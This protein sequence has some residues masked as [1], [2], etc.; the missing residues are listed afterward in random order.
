[1]RRIYRLIIFVLNG[2]IYFFT[3]I[4]VE[5]YGGFWKF[6]LSCKNKPNTLKSKMY[7]KYQH[8]NACGI[9]QFSYFKGYPILPHG[10]FGIFI[11]AGA[12]IGENCVIFHHVTIGSNTLLDSKS[13][14]SPTIGDNVYIGAGA[15]II[16]NVHIGSNVRIGANAIVVK[17]VADNSIVVLDSIKTITKSKPFDNSYYN[18]KTFLE[19]RENIEK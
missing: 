9:S 11:S 6:K 4:F 2:I 16:G 3:P 19:M 18:Y 8:D 14:G 10:F 15:K 5:L 7:D 1:M 12:S 17:D 13:A